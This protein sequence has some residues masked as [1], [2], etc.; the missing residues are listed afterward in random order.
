MRTYRPIVITTKDKKW[1]LLIWD[2]KLPQ[3]SCHQIKSR[4]NLQPVC[5][6]YNLVYYFYRRAGA[7]LRAALRH[8]DIAGYGITYFASPLF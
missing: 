4:A 8:I 5:T 1:D 2:L 3:V 6:F 7:V